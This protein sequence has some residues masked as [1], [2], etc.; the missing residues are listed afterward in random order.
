M[1]P[2]PISIQFS[3]S[4]QITQTD[5]EVTNGQISEFKQLSTTEV[6]LQIIPNTAGEVQITLSDSIQSTS[7]SIL[8]SPPVF[9]FVY[10]GVTLSSPS[11]LAYSRYAI[12]TVT[13]SKTVELYCLILPRSL[14]VTPSYSV[15]TT[16]GLAMSTVKDSTYSLNVTALSPT[17]EYVLYIAGREPFGPEIAT[18]IADTRTSFT[19]VNDGDKPSE[20]KQCPRGWNLSDGLLL[21]TQCS[22]HGICVD[23][24]CTCYSPYSGDSCSLIQGDEAVVNATHYT[25]HTRFT[26]T[27][28]LPDTEEE[29]DVFLQTTLQVTTAEALELTPSSVQIRLWEKTSVSS[30]SK[31]LRGIQ[32]SNTRFQQQE[33]PLY[34]RRLHRRGILPY[35]DMQSQETSQG[36]LYIHVW[37]IVTSDM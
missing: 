23:S 26:V 3:Q 6:S 18:P 30:Q 27:G 17:T 33:L 34:H 19:T 1:F 8:R 13:A 4:T 25:L 16:T 10:K 11:V 31:I 15:V 5:V 12:A 37:N 22:D 2:V 28:D 29:Q 9:T 21:F 24:Q 35:L 7:G 36:G 14:A 20:G 32:V